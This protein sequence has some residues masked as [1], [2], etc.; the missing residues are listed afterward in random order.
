MKLDRIHPPAGTATA[1]LIVLLLAT[2][3]AMAAEPG[4]R[5]EGVVGERDIVVDMDIDQSDW[6]GGGNTGGVSMTSRPVSPQDGLGR[7]SI[8]FEGSDFQAGRFHNAEVDLSVIGARGVVYRATLDDGLEL[9][10]Q[11]AAAQDGL[12]H[13]HGQARGTLTRQ[14]F[15]ERTRDDADTLEID[16]SFSVQIGNSY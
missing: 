5:I 15:P 7:L 6:Y 2:N 3:P 4:G 12:L 1:M 9:N 11:H 16:L 10:I 13:L 14:Q 8:G